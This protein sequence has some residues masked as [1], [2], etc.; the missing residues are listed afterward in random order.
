MKIIICD[1][2]AVVRDGLEMLL[3]LEKDIE[4]LGTAQDGAEAFGVGDT[5]PTRFGFNGLENARYERYRS[6]TSDPG[7]V[8]C[9]QSTGADHLR[10]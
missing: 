1:D 8:S 9:G 4:V 6:H 10:R 2:Q 7:K 5:K 3:T